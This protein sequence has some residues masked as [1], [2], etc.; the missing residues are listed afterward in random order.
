MGTYRL[1]GLGGLSHGS[2]FRKGSDVIDSEKPPGMS[3]PQDPPESLRETTFKILTG[4]SF[5]YSP[6]L[7]WFLMAVAVWCIFPYDLEPYDADDTESGVLALLELVKDRLVINHVLALL[8]IG[9]WHWALYIRGYCQRPFVPNRI[10]NTAKVIHNLFYTVLGIVQWTLVEG[11]FF[12]LYK[13]GRL[14][15]VDASTNP[16]TL[17]QTLIF[18]ILLPPFRDIHFYFVHRFIHTR[19]L[20][21][22]IHSLHHRNTD[23]E[24]FSGLA[25]HP[26]EHMHY[27]TCYAPLLVLPLY[28]GE[29]FVLSPFL[30]FWMGVHL[31]ITPAASHSG[32]EDHF[33]ADIGHYL[34]HRFCDC[35]FGAGINLDIIFGTYKATL[36]D[37][38]PIDGAN[39]DTKSIDINNLSTKAVS[40]PPADPKSSLGFPEHPI[41]NIG[42][43]GMVVWAFGANRMG[44][45]AWWTAVVISIGPSVWATVLALMSA[46]KSFSWKKACLAPFDKDCVASLVLHSGLGF[47][48]G[49]LPVTHLLFLVFE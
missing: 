44:S 5:C 16:R 47:I 1:E 26:V 41:Y 45:P 33:S 40:H 37:I 24:P 9:F 46:P 4:E 42:V 29:T 48:L 8:Y 15:Y 6:N 27:F 31:V 14:P 36:V 20:Y 12:H 17:L 23:V 19:P 13:S 30:V 2:F 3:L 18:S 22:Y 10:Y 25:M 7:S 32:Y 34:H 35:N 11:A 49:V 43:I 28:F 38:K 39:S 21:K